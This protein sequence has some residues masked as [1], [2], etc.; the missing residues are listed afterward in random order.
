MVYRLNLAPIK[1][2]TGF[3]LHIDRLVLKFSQKC[4]ALRIAKTNEKEEQSGANSADF[5]PCYKATG[6]RTVVLV[7]RQTRGPSEQNRES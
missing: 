1:I 7:Q 4:K 6:I 3:L 2:L 5:E